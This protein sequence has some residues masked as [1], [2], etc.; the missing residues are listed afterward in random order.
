M[1]VDR[2]RPARGHCG[3][4]GCGAAGDPPRWLVVRSTEPGGVRPVTVRVCFVTCARWPD[5]S[6]SDGHVQRALQARGVAVEG[7]AWNLP[8]VG[9]NGFDGVVLRSNWDYH[10]E[11]EAFAA[12]LDR[13]EEAGA[14]IWNPPPLVRWNLTKRYLLELAAAGVDVVPT[15]LLDERHPEDLARVMHEQGWDPAVVKP[16]ISASGHDTVLL[17]RARVDEVV[18]GLRAGTIRTPAMVQPFIPEIRHGEW[19]LVFVDGEFTH[20]AVKRPADGDFRVQPRHGGSAEA[21]IPSDALIG[22]ALRVLRALPLAPLYA[23][24]DGV[25]RAGGFLVMEVELNEPGL[26]YQ[27]APLAADRLAEAIVR[28]LRRAAHGSDEAHEAP[29]SGNALAP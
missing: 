13:W 20:G 14:R 8:G 29:S 27:Y 26:L 19:S 16:V 18:A 1:A 2:H 4:G 11:P 6:E 10:F 23:R 7:R 12:W 5:I 24:I 3:R 21:A 22:A 17:T 25:E 28:R 15:R 9:F